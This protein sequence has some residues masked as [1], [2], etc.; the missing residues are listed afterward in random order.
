MSG[1]NIDLG[2]EHIAGAMLSSTV[3]AFSAACLF[4]FYF[5]AFSAGKVQTQQARVPC[6]L[7]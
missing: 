7:S 3:H 6:H 2:S 5:S 1:M 4:A